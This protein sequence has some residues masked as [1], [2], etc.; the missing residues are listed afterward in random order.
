MDIHP[1]DHGATLHT[2]HGY[3]MVDGWP[4]CPS[5][6]AELKVIS[7]PTRFSVPKPPDS[8]SKARP[9]PEVLALNAQHQKELDNFSAK[10][11]D[12]RQYRFEKNGKAASGAQRYVCPARAG[13]IVCSQCPLSQLHPEAAS[14]PQMT[15]PEG[16]VL[17]ACANETMSLKSE[18][19]LK[20]RQRLY[21]GSPEWISEYSQRTRVEGSFGRMKHFSTG[22]V[23]RG[24]IRQMGLVKTGL[25][26]VLA[27]AT[28]NLTQLLLW[29]QRTGNTSDPLTTM[30]TTSYGFVELD[31][32]GQ[33]LLENPPPP[34]KP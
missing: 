9:R 11:A 3:L 27:V 16:K 19:G 6:P 17:S 7:R 34:P 24:W 4:H 21:W 22:G 26:L 5:M 1:N 29:S 14:K 20:L 33:P 25:A 18:V 23:R 12:R 28:V 13:K 15:P 2:E 30:D 32:H 8:D 31:E 10:I